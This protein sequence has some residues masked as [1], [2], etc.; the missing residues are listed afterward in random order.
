MLDSETFTEL[1]AGAG[2]SARRRATLST[3]PSASPGGEL[4]LGFTAMP[5]STG[6]GDL[7]RVGLDAV[8]LFVGSTDSLTNEN[9][10][11][12]VDEAAREH[13]ASRS[14]RGQNEMNTRAI[15]E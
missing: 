7:S 11:D 14:S 3:G 10:I 2:T 12:T 1:A 5:N 8:R 4:W 13:G 9:D 6:S 15:L